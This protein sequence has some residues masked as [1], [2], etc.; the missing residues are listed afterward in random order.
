MKRNIRTS[1]H[2]IAAASAMLMIILFF[3]SSF[4]AELT[5]NEVFIIRVKTGIFYTLPLMLIVMPVLGLSGNQLAAKSRHPL[6]QQKTKRMKW[7]AF[8][9]MLLVTLAVLLYL[10]AKS[11]RIDNIFQLLQLTELLVG[12]T[13]LVLMS[14]MVRDGKR[15]SGSKKKMKL[16]QV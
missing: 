1:I 14:L 8:N 10:R 15:L 7:I 4:I 2:K 12:G 16:T 9:G 3:T 5:A 13:N 6:V 11:G